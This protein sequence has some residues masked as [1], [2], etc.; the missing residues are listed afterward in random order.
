[1]AAHRLNWERAARLLLLLLLLGVPGITLAA[2]QTARSHAVEIHALMPEDGGWLPG[3]LTAEV[4]QPLHLHLTSD[5]V[6]HGFAVGRMEGPPVDVNPGQMTELTLTFE[7]PGVYTYYCTRWCGANHWRM[8]GTIKVGG[9]QPADTG[10]SHPPL[11]VELGIDL[12]A[13]H[14]AAVVPAAPP[15]PLQG[16]AIASQLPAGALSTYLSR[17]LYLTQSPEQVWRQLGEDPLL[18]ELTGSQRWD[19]VAMIWQAMISSENTAVAA[20]LYSQQCAAC[21]GRG[22]AG[23]GIMLSDAG[24]YSMADQMGDDAM[25]NA[26]FTDP[27]QML[28]ASSALLYGKIAR[29]GMGTG[30][31]N[32]GTIYT[33][34]QIWALVDY[35]WSFQFPTAEAFE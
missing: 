34:E 6:V 28:G 5:D 31:P 14:Q 12:D 8:R 9:G 7:E 2:R 29:G 23:D 30:M 21:H 32:W 26:D 4:G 33:D 18:N 25:L 3:D 17:D 35:L 22:G 11:F 24:M 27:G 1:M 16:Q 19:L 15:S 20:P 10:D 13:S